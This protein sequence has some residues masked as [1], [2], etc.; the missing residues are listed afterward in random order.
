M[1]KKPMKD[2]I[3]LLPGITGSV[4]QRNGKDVWAFS[5][6]AITRGLFSLGRSVKDLELPA[7]D[8]A[9]VDDLGDGVTAPR[10]MSDIHLIPG[11]WKIDGYSKVGTAIKSSFDVTP[12]ENY[13]EFAYDWRR[14]NRVAA[15]R[16]ARQSHDWLKAWRDRSGAADAKLIL[17]GHSMGGLVSRYFLECMDGWKDTRMLVTF[18]TPYRGSLNAIRFVAEGMSKKVLGLTVIDLSPMLRSFTSVYQLLPVYPC[19]DLGSGDPVRVT[20]TDRIANLDAARAGA[21]LEFH[22]EIRQAV[23]DHEKEDAYLAGRYQIHPI[24]GTF[25]PTLQ[26]VKLDGDRVE[27]LRHYGGEDQDG[28]G[29][30]PRVSATP[31][32]LGNEPHAMFASERHGSLQNFDPVLVQLHGALTQRAVD[33]SVYYAFN[34]KLSLDID[35]AYEALEPIPVRVKPEQPGVD[36]TAAVENV[37]TGELAARTGLS[38]GDEG[39]HEGMVPPLAPGAYRLTVRG[40]FAVD[41]VTD[42]FTVLPAAPDPAWET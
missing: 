39:W 3:V 33:L 32:E 14:D 21:A 19:V 15:R 22:S 23:D 16:L 12:G 8:P 29:T 37:D 35:D 7:E 4:L 6:G 40:E 27:F 17:V 30:V 13:F 1:P 2:V 42:V 20:E 34:T 28:D 25:Q 18:G 31:Y 41:P 26:S 11:L 38:A 9:E 36:L 10:V 24:V 5:G